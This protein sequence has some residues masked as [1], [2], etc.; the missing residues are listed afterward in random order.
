MAN[1][2]LTNVAIVAIVAIFVAGIVVAGGFATITG[3]AVA[4]K[5]NII[6]ICSFYKEADTTETGI[7]L[8][9]PEL[10]T[11]ISI[12]SCNQYCGLQNVDKTKSMSV[13]CEMDTRCDCTKGKDTCAGYGTC[14]DCNAADGC[15]W[16][17][18]QCA[19]ESTVRACEVCQVGPEPIGPAL[20]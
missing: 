6:G 17:S 1:D 10:V 20:R 13:E 7:T 19:D 15:C 2:K 4:G 14:S 11:S 9:K 3:Y 5:G 16:D 18:G 8:E 12:H